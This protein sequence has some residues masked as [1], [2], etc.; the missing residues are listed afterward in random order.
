M[1]KNR[2]VIY[3]S[4]LSFLIALSTQCATVPAPKGWLPKPSEAQSWAFGG[5]MSIEYSSGRGEK[6]SQGELIA[7][8]DENI[9]LLTAEELAVVPINN[10]HNSAIY[11]YKN[12][13]DSVGIWALLGTLSTISHGFYALI[14]APIWI[15]SGSLNASGESKSGCLKY[16]DKDWQEFRKFARFPQGIPQ[17]LDLQALKPKPLGK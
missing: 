12:S 2:L 11:V 7:I 8:Q 5:W 14:S 13:V 16:P 4:G 9:Y 10:V 6:T 17:G 3:I 15:I 1:Q